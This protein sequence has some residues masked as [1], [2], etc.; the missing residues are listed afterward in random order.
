MRVVSAT[1]LRAVRTL[2]SPTRVRNPSVERRA[3][4][5]V[6][7]VRRQ[8]DRAL[9]RYAADLDGVTGP[10]EVPSADWERAARSLP[11][12]V[13]QAM[14]RAAV[15]IRRI[16]RAQRPHAFRATVVPGVRV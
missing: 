3:A 5:I 16:A 13:R 7:D 12:G 9:R 4:R 15:H 1:D 14:R 2:L 10:I 6:L 8:G 11:Q